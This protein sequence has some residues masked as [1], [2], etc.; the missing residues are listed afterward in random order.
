MGLRLREI[1]RSR[2]A[3]QESFARILGVAT[4]TYCKYEHH[5]IAITA[6]QIQK[7]ASELGLPIARFFEEDEDEHAR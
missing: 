3:S 1:R 2:K 7:L 4:S 5:T 6:Q